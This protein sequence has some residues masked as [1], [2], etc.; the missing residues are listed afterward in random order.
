M[1]S[2]KRDK[3]QSIL[4]DFDFT[5]EK[6]LEVVQTSQNRISDLRIKDM[7]KDM[8]PMSD[9][10]IEENGEGTNLRSEQI[11]ISKESYPSI[12]DKNSI[13]ASI[14]NISRCSHKSKNLFNQ[15]LFQIRQAFFGKMN[16]CK[17]EK[18][19]ELRIKIRSAL[20]KFKENG[21]NYKNAVYKLLDKY[22]KNQ[23]NESD[24]YSWSAQAAQQTINS[25]VE[26]WYDYD[27]AREDYE[28]HPEKYTGR[29]KIPK[30][31]KGSEYI[32][33]FTNQQCKVETKNVFVPESIQSERIRYVKK[34]F[35]TFPDH[36]RIKPIETRLSDKDGDL[37]E[38]RIVPQI[39]KGCYKVELVYRKVIDKEKIRELNL[40]PLRV[41]GIDTGQ[42]NIVTIANNIGSSPIVIKGGVLLAINQWFDKI[43]SKLYSVYYR[44]QKTVEGKTVPIGAKMRNLSFNRKNLVLD[45]LHKISRFIVNYCVNNR[46]GTIVWGRNPGWKQNISIGKRNNQ[47]F[48]KIPHY[49]LFKMLKYKSEENGIRVIDVEESWTSKCSFLD[50]EPIGHKDKYVGRRI[51]RGL[52]RSSLGIIINA[53][54]N[55]AYNLIRKV[56]P[57]AFRTIG[58]GGVVL[59]P[60]RLSIK[61]LLSNRPAIVNLR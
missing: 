55:A 25:A 51:K 37:R 53:D 45:I 48:T 14:D 2:T 49:L 17:D 9:M 34:N 58:I 19:K 50:Q 27:L 32:A 13:L 52:F 38:V 22:F 60:E 61:D 12:A 16:D 46:I 20:N 39:K 1:K 5:K 23:G 21:F 42:E 30:Y 8:S 44:Q 24:N 54:V 35:V 36:L 40:D 28:K 10:S 11:I 59:H 6:K 3:F 43:G 47:K 26:A 41:I 31:R 57:E 15:S 18:E 56:F 33:V 29:P 4:F 7:S